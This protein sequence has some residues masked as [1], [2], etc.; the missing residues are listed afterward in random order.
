MANRIFYTGVIKR[1]IGKTLNA[2]TKP[3][4]GCEDK[5]SIIVEKCYSRTL[6]RTMNHNPLTEVQRKKVATVKRKEPSVKGGK[7]INL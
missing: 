6:F 4:S 3:L 7:L 2:A 5:H 1:K